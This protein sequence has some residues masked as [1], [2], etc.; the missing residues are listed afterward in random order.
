MMW[1][2]MTVL[3][4]LLAT[5]PGRAD[6]PSSPMGP[7]ARLCRPAISAAERAHSIPSHLLAAIGRVESG[8]RDS[9]SDTFNPWPWTAN[10]EG[11]GYFYDSKAQAVAAVLEMQKQ[12]IRSIDVGCM[13]ISL[14]HHPDAFPS[15]EQAFDPAANADYGGRFLSQLHDQSNSWPRAVEMY[16]SA[17]PEI[18]EEYGRRV[19]AALPEEQRLAG[20]MPTTGLSPS[21]GL[22][23]SESLATTLSATFIRSPFSAVFRPSPARV[24]ALP[25][26]AQLGT[27]P[28]RTLD[29][30]RAAPIRLAF[31][32]P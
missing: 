18:G 22:L 29:A 17:T 24:I 23:P 25:S 28:G 10:A 11:Q 1:R 14:L 5:S 13:Q 12:G 6:I 3:L 15:L 31:R 32:S 27:A 26:T 8:R 7:S 19:Y 2:A 16:H 30:Y 4:V 20:L 9:A 21:A